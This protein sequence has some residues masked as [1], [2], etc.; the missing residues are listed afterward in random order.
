MSDA[1]RLA[2]TLAGWDD[3]ALARL[4]RDRGLP[5]AGINGML[6]LAEALVEPS[7]VR[8][9]LASLPAATLAR[10]RDHGSTPELDA[11]AL[12]IDGTPLGVVRRL[13]EHAGPD[14]ATTALPVPADDA[15][16]VPDIERGLESTRAVREIVTDLIVHPLPLL[17][18]GEPSA[19][20]T[21]DLAAALGTTVDTVP[22]LIDLAVDAGLAERAGR[23]LIADD[24]ATAF[25]TASMASQWTALVA[26]WRATTGAELADALLSGA[27]IADRFPLDDGRIARRA[28][29]AVASAALLGLWRDDA[30]TPLGTRARAGGASVTE[31]V[32]AHAPHT[33][34]EVYVQGDGTI[35]APGPLSGSLDL[36]L[37]RF[38]SIEQRGLAPQW[39]LSSLSISDALR[40]GESLDEF[41][42]ALA[43]ASRSGVPQPVEYVIDETARRFGTVRVRPLHPDR[44]GRLPA[45]RATAVRSSD[46]PLLDTMQAD[47]SLSA[48]GLVRVGAWRLETKAHP[49]AVVRALADARYPVALEDDEGTIVPIRD[50]AAVAPAPTDAV[51]R[52]V[53]RLRGTAPEH[54]AARDAWIERQLLSAVRDKAAVRVRVDVPGAA[55]RDFVLRPLGIASGRVRAID[56]I[57][58]VERTLPLSLVTE[59]RPLDG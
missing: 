23:V 48:L 6:D 16:L 58:D 42:T 8:G 1:I 53:A 39:R 28:A 14:L 7:N 37:R 57:A 31:V 56:T 25:A 29:R 40:R 52:L 47:R 54:G 49:D 17:A 33:G 46:E 43:A 2:D 24:G 35:V 12:G 45:G 41:R 3:D 5:L 50:H 44:D 27:A 20:T 34:D 21:R 55:P 51:G 38:A 15:A 11:L 59:I 19:A 9:A 26:T 13:A 36:L 18:R 22:L 32:A 30:P 10:I 4:I